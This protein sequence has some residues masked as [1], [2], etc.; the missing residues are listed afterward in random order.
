[1]GSYVNQSLIAGERIEANATISWLSQFWYFV[2]ALLCLIASVNAPGLNALTAIFVIVAILNVITT[3]LAVTNKKIIGKSGFI[4][5]SSIDI[6]IRKC[7][8][9]AV[10][11]SITGRI[12]GYGTV[13]TRGTGGNEVGIAF[14][15]NPIQFRKVI[16]TVMDKVQGDKEY[17]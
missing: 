7:E 11:Q 12:L 1:M 4:R 9:I 16:M 10:N 6:P 2:L 17:E 3:E 15:K 13:V 14:I 5:R 8:S